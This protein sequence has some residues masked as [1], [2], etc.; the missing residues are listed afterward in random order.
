MD[1]MGYNTTAKNQFPYDA[2]A[3]LSTHVLAF[4]SS[5]T[6]ALTSDPRVPNGIFRHAFHAL[7]D[8][9]LSDVFGHLNL[10]D[11]Q[12]AAVCLEKG[13]LRSVVKRPLPHRYWVDGTVDQDGDGRRVEEMSFM[14][15]VYSDGCGRVEY[16]LVNY[17]DNVSS[18]L[19]LVRLLLGDV[20]GGIMTYEWNE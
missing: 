2:N 15:F 4:P 12:C 8:D 6:D 19:V 17:H 7:S 20:T 3:R 10:H 18:F 9:A 13:T 16:G 5:C 14:D 11:G 1:K